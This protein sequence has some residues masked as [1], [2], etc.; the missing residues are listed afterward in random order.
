M[1]LKNKLLR[2]KETDRNYYSFFCDK[3][4]TKEK[5][6]ILT[7]KDLLLC[8]DEYA[9]ESIKEYNKHFIYYKI[10]KVFYDSS[11]LYIPISIT[12]YKKSNSAYADKFVIL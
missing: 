2:I 1:F 6:V 11:I 9:A 12:K 5:F 4:L 8:I 7:K 10:I 3:E